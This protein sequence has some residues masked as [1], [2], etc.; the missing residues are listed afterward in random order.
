MGN[1]VASEIVKLM[2]N[3]DIKVKGS[4]TLMLGITFKENC[5][6]IRNTKAIDVYRELEQYGTTVELYDPWANPAE[7]MHEYGIKTTD[8]ANDLAGKYD[9]VVL[10]VAHKEFLDA[11]VKQFLK[12]GGVLA[13]TN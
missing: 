11:D 12:P 6:D 3:K 7:V 9:A 10:T 5:P 13:K 2:I 1:Y 8:Q 4:K